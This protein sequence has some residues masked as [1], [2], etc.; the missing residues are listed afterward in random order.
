MKV[1]HDSHTFDLLPNSLAISE[2]GNSLFGL[3]N[4]SSDEF[5]LI[6]TP[7]IESNFNSVRS[8]D[9]IIKIYQ[10]NHWQEGEFSNLRTKVD[11]EMISIGYAFPITTLSA[12]SISNIHQTDPAAAWYALAATWELLKSSDYERT[13][14]QVSWGETYVLTDFFRQ[15]LVIAI[16]S[17]QRVNSD[18][19]AAEKII[20]SF[21]ITLAQHKIFSYTGIKSKEKKQTEGFIT[22]SHLNLSPCT[23]IEKRPFTDYVTN[24]LITADSTDCDP[25]VRFFLQYQFF[26]LLMQRIFSEVISEFRQK[27]ASENYTSDAWKT[28][29]LVSKLGEKTSEN[30]RIS[31][32]FGFMLEKFRFE[33][34][35]IINNC[36]V[37]LKK[38]EIQKAA[39]PKDYSDAKTP[40]YKVRNVIFHGF[41]S[42][43]IEKEDITQICDSVEKITYKLSLCFENLAPYFEIESTAQHAQED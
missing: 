34:E 24:H 6:E 8:S 42:H 39:D 19:S 1:E 37:L 5:I 28:K 33:T 14:F 26:E 32:I 4:G 36:K 30:Y 23:D 17:P 3:Y 18:R 2:S 27:I 25:L 13:P 43:S 35:E 21:S 31:R 9:N 15:D 38:I 16:Y 41:A 29:E 7:K 22:A 10:S 11:G 12:D 40:Y 20:D